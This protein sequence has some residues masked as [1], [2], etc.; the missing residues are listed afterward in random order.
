MRPQT[1]AATRREFT[2]RDFYPYRAPETAWESYEQRLAQRSYRRNFFVGKD[3]VDA[4]FTRLEAAEADPVRLEREAEDLIKG[5]EIL[6]R[7]RPGSDAAKYQHMP[8]II[9]ASA[10]SAMMHLCQKTGRTDIIRQRFADFIP[11][12][13]AL[14]DLA[15]SEAQGGRLNPE[16]FK[17]IYEFKGEVMR[18]DMPR[19]LSSASDSIQEISVPDALAA[20]SFVCGDKINPAAIRNVFHE[21]WE[22]PSL[23]PLMEVL[24][25]A[26]AGNFCDD[27]GGRSFNNARRTTI[28]FSDKL[29]MAEKPASGFTDGFPH[30]SPMVVA[31]TIWPEKFHEHGTFFSNQAIKEILAHEFHHH[32]EAQYYQNSFLPYPSSSSHERS[33]SYGT[34]SNAEIK[35]RLGRM[36]EEARSV[37]K[38]GNIEVVKGFNPG[39]EVG[40]SVLEPYD[41]FSRIAAYHEKDLHKEVVVL[42]SQALAKMCETGGCEEAHALQIMRDCG[43][44]ECVDFFFEEREKMCSALENLRHAVGKFAE[45]APMIEIAPTEQPQKAAPSAG[46]EERKGD[47]E[48]L[49]DSTATAA[50]A[51]SPSTTIRP[52]ERESESQMRLAG[53][54]AAGIGTD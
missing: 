10:F 38:D 30:W 27:K 44:N 23:K 8:E 49:S 33:R 19:A 53:S 37:K 12:S 17:N 25:Y 4:L 6:T 22:V 48:S 34:D 40:I 32:W 20:S 51:A 46:A 9:A 42:V 28:V 36:I 15:F 18:R 11:V 43:L 14:S 24:A 52:R 35:A 16:L 31:S 1:T 50:G 39:S 7:K 45:A 29:P 47:E 2:F 54:A 3:E 26:T 41:T 21:M 13:S 5:C